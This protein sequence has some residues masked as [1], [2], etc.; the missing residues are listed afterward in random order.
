MHRIHR[1]LDVRLF[2]DSVENLVGSS[3]LGS[4][5]RL[6]AWPHKKPMRCSLKDVSLRI[7]IEKVATPNATCLR[8]LGVSRLPPNP[9]EATTKMLLAHSLKPL[10]SHIL[11]LAHSASSF[12]SNGQQTAGKQNLFCVRKFLRQCHKLVSHFRSRQ[13][14]FA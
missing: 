13:Y 5:N 12:A 1:N 6:S 3:K 8:V 10:L 11:A 4:W 9:S 7:C 14:K 2:V